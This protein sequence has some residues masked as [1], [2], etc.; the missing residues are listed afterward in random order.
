M[1][2]QVALPVGDNP[3]AL[4]LGDVTGDGRLDLATANLGTLNVAGELVGGGKSLLLHSTAVG[5]NFSFDAVITLQ[6]PTGNTYTAISFTSLNNLLGN[7]P[8]TFG[9]LV[10]TASL[11]FDAPTV[12]RV[13]HNGG[14]GNPFSALPASTNVS[15]PD[16]NDVL[17]LG[18]G[19][20]DGDG[21]QDVVVGHSLS[22]SVSVLFG[23]GNGAFSPEE[24]VSV[25]ESQVAL[26]TADLNQDGILDVIVLG[27]GNVHLLVGQANGSLLLAESFSVGSAPR[28]VATGD[29][30]GDGVPDVVVAKASPASLLLF[31]SEP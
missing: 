21:A 2:F 3:T 28:A 30:N 13:L 9:D 24:L 7:A 29:V 5:I 16:A 31:V 1:Q 6:N 12:E 10:S 25:G 22:N 17:V 19:D 11:G 20:V 14:T 26:S 15:P 4:A 23:I 27:A 8:D 18:T